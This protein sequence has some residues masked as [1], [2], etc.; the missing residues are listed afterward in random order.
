LPPVKEVIN[1]RDD[2]LSFQVCTCHHLHKISNEVTSKYQEHPRCLSLDLEEIHTLHLLV[3][4]RPE[5]CLEIVRQKY[6]YEQ[7]ILTAACI[8]PHMIIGV[9]V[10]GCNN[11]SFCKIGGVYR[12]IPWKRWSKP[13]KTTPSNTRRTPSRRTASS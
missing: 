2:H 7:Q 8:S 5:Y 13:C 12:V 3:P 11:E 10:C 6:I 4:E 1:I 9:F